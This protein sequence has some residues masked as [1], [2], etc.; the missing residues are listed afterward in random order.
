MNLFEKKLN[1][2]AYKQT[3]NDNNDHKIAPAS[4]LPLKKSFY[5]EESSESSFLINE[6]HHRSFNS[7]NI[8]DQSSDIF[9]QQELNDHSDAGN[10]K[11]E[12]YNCSP[13]ENLINKLNIKINRKPI[14]DDR[15]QDMDNQKF[16]NKNKCKLNTKKIQIYNS[17]HKDWEQENEEAK[18]VNN[19]KIKI[20]KPRTLLRRNS[21][22]SYNQNIFSEASQL[23][24]V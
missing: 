7:Q 23:T 11:D 17:N 15:T 18:N 2:D 20:N 1:N 8:K 3:I 14:F 5:I 4:K 13:I 6:K 24:T 12:T 19:S 21:T 16:L 22:N 10:E 9:N